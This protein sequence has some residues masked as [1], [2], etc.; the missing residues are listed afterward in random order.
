M[1]AD[2]EAEWEDS[3][4]VAALEAGEAVMEEAD[5]AALEAVMEEAEEA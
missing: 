1:E 3:E 4:A 5:L 2:T